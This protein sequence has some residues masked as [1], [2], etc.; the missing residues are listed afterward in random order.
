MRK[1]TLV[2]TIFIL[3]LLTS[4]TFVNTSSRTPQEW[5]TLANSG[6]AGRDNYSYSAQ[7]ETGINNNVQLSTNNFTGQVHS[8]QEYSIN[9]SEVDATLLH[10]AKYMD[11]INNADNTITYINE[12][13]DADA[14]QLILPFRIEEP[15]EKAT[16]R[17]KSLLEQQF[18]QIK[19]STE[20]MSIKSNKTE[21]VLRFIANSENELEGMLRTLTVNS[22]YKL[23]IDPVDAIP[24]SLDEYAVLQYERDGKPYREYRNSKIHFKYE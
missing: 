11:V 9:S 21:E 10:P 15:S 14:A 7:V 12:P 22:T 18:N 1:N 16:A 24:L 4:C 8:H 5:V 23:I 20:Q 17:W 6:L 3:L 13:L 19:L 2:V